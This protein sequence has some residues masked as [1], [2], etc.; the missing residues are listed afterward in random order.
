MRNS[1]SRPSYLSR[2]KSYR[3]DKI[4]YKKAE[5][6]QNPQPKLATMFIVTFVYCPIFGLIHTF[7]EVN[8]IP[9]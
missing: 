8:F 3:T 7:K 2:A 9:S 5:R 6:W 4:I 1:I